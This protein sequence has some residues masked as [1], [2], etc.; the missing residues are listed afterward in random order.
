[1]S[2]DWIDIVLDV[3]AAY[4]RA[5]GG[6]LYDENLRSRLVPWAN[7]AFKEIERIRR[8]PFAYGTAQQI[9]TAGTQIYAIPAGI[10]TIS[11][12]YYLDSTGTPIL[13]ALYDTMQ[14]R[15]SYGEGSAATPGPPTKWSIIGTNIEIFPV[16]DSSGPTSGNYTL[17]FEGYQALT[18]IVE[19][20]STPVAL[21]TSLTVP[22]TGY[23]VNRGVVT[24]GT[25]GL[26]IRGAGFAYSSTGLDSWLTNWSAFP[27]ATHVTV[28]TA[29]ITAQSNA[30]TFF[31][32]VNWLITD[33]P[34]VLEFAV[35]REV[36]TY[37]KEDY[38]V[39]ENRYQHEVDLM[40]DFAADRQTSIE[41]FATFTPGQRGL[42]L[43]RL[44]GWY[45][46]A[47]GVWPGV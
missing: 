15:E 16:P 19:T 17:I 18:P 29:P 11:N 43:R 21:G 23:L 46:C 47:Y 25:T 4:L 41:Q 7:N 26:S 13:L 8:W 12:L 32:S 20:V 3:E 14:M 22:T 38:T 24:S 33:F 36:A 6:T 1:M 9:T 37:L 31:N 2:R 34:K 44:D 27:D 35:M 39:W 5:T 28:T 10:T 40:G 45:N 30:Q 42:Q